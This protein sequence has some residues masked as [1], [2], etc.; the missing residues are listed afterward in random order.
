MTEVSPEG[1]AGPELLPPPSIVNAGELG[2]HGMRDLRSLA[3]RVATAGLVA[4]DPGPATA[5]GVALEGSSLIV[6]GTAHP[7]AD[8]ARIAVLGAGKASLRIAIELERVLGDR[9]DGGTV[10]VRSGDGLRLSRIEVLE[11]GH[12]LPTAASAAAGRRLLERAAALGPD[13]LAIACFTG[14]SSALA[15]APPPGVSLADKRELNRVLLS[16]GLPIT[17]INLVRRHVSEIK[18]GRLAAAVAPARVVNLTVSD[19]AGDPLDAITDPTVPD[20]TTPT[21]AVELLRGTGLW[22]AL[23]DSVRR[24][25]SNAATV[26]PAVDDVPTLLL[27]NGRSACDAMMLEASRAGV[28]SVMLSTTLEGE[29]REV[30]GVLATLARE[31]AERSAPFPA[32]CVLLGCGGETT[33]RLAAGASFGSGGPNQEAALG[34]ALALAPHD[35]VAAAFLDTDGSDGGTELAGGLVDGLTTARAHNAGTDLRAVLRDHAATR[36]FRALGDGI[37]TGRTGTNANDLFVLAIG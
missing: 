29:S 17:E 20:A 5:D 30:G 9:L 11:A 34:A 4:C 36:A 33:V 22:R 3:L 10:V 27:V 32:P 12:P 37:V 21:E 24:H 2:Q 1:L 31:S 6:G 15:C 19:V 28:R 14:G 13:D 16:S 25:L 26:R 23:P 18:G 35:R 8:G 7:L